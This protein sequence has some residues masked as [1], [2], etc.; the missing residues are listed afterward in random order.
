M[1]GPPVSP[2]PVFTCATPV[3]SAAGAHCAPFHFNTLFDPGAVA[4]TARPWICDTTDAP[5]VPVT[6]PAIAVVS[7]SVAGAH[8]DPFHFN[9]LFS[10]GAAL[11]T[12][13]FCTPVTASTPAP[14]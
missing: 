6:S 9:T 10:P 3:A 7:A 5:C 12:A 13:R 1:I 11:D 8:C 14:L 4:S 2:L